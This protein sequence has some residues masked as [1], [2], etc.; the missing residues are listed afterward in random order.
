MT[1]FAEKAKLWKEE[2]EKLSEKLKM[3][4]EDEKKLSKIKKIMNDCN[5]GKNISVF[6]LLYNMNGGGEK[7]S[8]L[9]TGENAVSQYQYEDMLLIL[10]EKQLEL[11]QN[12]LE[13][14]KE[15]LES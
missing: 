4:I 1:S 9:F 7:W 15:F 8:E 10:T 13:K 12:Y 14:D 5:D 11:M 3:D 6:T 2:A